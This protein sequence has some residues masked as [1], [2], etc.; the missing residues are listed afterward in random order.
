MLSL[1]GM[2]IA[3]DAYGPI[4]DNAGGIAEMAGLPEKTRQITDALDAVGNTTKAVTKGYAIGAAALA[5]LVLFSAYTQDV[6]HYL[7][8]DL[9]FD[10]GNHFVIMGL[11]VGST[12]PYL[13]SALSMKA[14]SR[15]GAAVV[16][17][18]RHQFKTIA[19]IM[20]Y[21]TGQKKQKGAP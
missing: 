6:S 18:V 15:A 19:G 17:E 5:A 3:I 14:V 16:E 2:I 10:L 4:T 21:T 9:Q 7:G 8:I 1:M 12:V 13:F 11:L 20:D